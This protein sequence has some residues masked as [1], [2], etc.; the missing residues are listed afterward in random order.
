[1][2]H[3]LTL[4]LV[5]VVMTITSKLGGGGTVVLRLFMKGQMWR[6]VDTPEEEA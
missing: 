4:V 5:G 1:M 3:G 6:V 2:C